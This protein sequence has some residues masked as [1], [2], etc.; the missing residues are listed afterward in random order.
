[1]TRSGLINMIYFPVINRKEGIY[2]KEYRR[3]FMKMDEEKKCATTKKTITN[4]I[5]KADISKGRIR[6]SKKRK[7]YQEQL[8]RIIEGYAQEIKELR[9]KR[10]QSMEKSNQETNDDQPEL[11]EVLDV[12]NNKDQEYTGHMDTKDDEKKKARKREADDYLVAAK[13]KNRMIG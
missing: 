4:K 1:M 13:W 6:H 2:R 11:E 10:D 8:D 7:G 12:N 9:K 3:S 5:L